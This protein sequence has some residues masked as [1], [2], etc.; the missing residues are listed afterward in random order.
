MHHG[1]S[2]DLFL[3]T[4]R[5]MPTANAEGWIE[6]EGSIGKVSVRRVFVPSDRQRSSA[7]AVGV[8]RNVAQDRSRQTR[9]ASR[10][11]ELHSKAGAPSG[12]SFYVYEKALTTGE[13]HPVMVHAAPRA[14]PGLRARPRAPRPF[15]LF[16]S[17]GKPRSTPTAI[18]DGEHRPADTS[19]A[20]L[21]ATV[22][23]LASRPAPRKP[24]GRVA[25]RACSEKK[26][27]RKKGSG[28]PT[29][30]AHGLNGI[31]HLYTRRG[32]IVE[33][34]ETIHNVH[35]FRRFFSVFFFWQPFGAC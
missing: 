4:F 1:P 35:M 19:R 13:L 23:P 25:A 24:L 20:R 18:A 14:A 32:A 12:P 5:R 27:K 3:E 29:R 2:V 26:M 15:F 28:A 22:R 17:R 6:S 34:W 30:V 21:A 11:G 10:S 7:C 31:L 9:D 33:F 16:S 8:R